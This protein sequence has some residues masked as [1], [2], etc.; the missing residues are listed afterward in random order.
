MK[1]SINNWCLTFHSHL[2]EPHGRGERDRERE[3][4]R[5]REGE[6]RDEVREKQVAE[7]DRNGR[8]V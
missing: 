2:R 6:G 7:E 8:E 1:I 5:E 4:E 3:R